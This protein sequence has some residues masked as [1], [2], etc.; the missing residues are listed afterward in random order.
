[1]VIRSVNG[2]FHHIPSTIHTTAAA[3]F[4]SYSRFNTEHKAS[5]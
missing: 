2:T 3:T 5:E 1:M 4:S